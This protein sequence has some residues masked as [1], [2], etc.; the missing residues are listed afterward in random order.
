MKHNKVYAKI[1]K[2]YGDMYLAIKSGPAFVNGIDRVDREKRSKSNQ[3]AK[4]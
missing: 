4:T 2:E 3:A 1:E